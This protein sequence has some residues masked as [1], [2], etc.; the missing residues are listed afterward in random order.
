M[1]NLTREELEAI[2]LIK[3]ERAIWTDMQVQLTDKVYFN[4]QN[5]IK[6]AKK[7][8]FGVF[9]DQ[10]D[11]VTK[12]KK[13]WLPLSRD[14]IETTVKNI[15]IDSK[16][17]SVRAKKPDSYYTAALVRYLL[18]AYLD[19]IN[20]GQLLNRVIRKCSTEGVAVLKK[21]NNGKNLTVSLVENLNFLTD[22]TCNYLKES[23]GN[24][25]NHWLTNY[26]LSTYAWDNLD[27]VVGTTSVERIQNYPVPSQIPY[28][29]ITERWGI[30]PK[31]LLTQNPADKT[32]Y[33]EGVIIVSNI[34]TNP[35]VH[36]IAENKTGKRPY[37]EFRTKMYDGRWLGIGVAEDLFDLQA[38]INEIFNIRL[39]TARIKQL[40]LFEI[41]KG[42]GITP[43]K[44]AQLYAGGGIL[45]SQ[46]GRDI[47]ELQTTDTKV[48]SYKDEDQAY[49]WSQRLTGAWEIGR[50][51]QLPATMP[52]TTAMLQQ[53]GM[54]TGFSLQQEELG[55]CISQFIEDLILPDMLNNLTDKDIVRITGDPKELKALDDTYVNNLVNDE[56]VNY[57]GRNGYYPT[58]M[59]IES[60]KQKLMTELAKQG[61]DRFLNIKKSIFKPNDIVDSVD[62]FVTGEGFD[63]MVM[64]RQLNDL[65]VNYSRI[66]GVNIDQDKIVAELLDLMGL[67][68]ERFIRNQPVQPVPMN[69][70]LAPQ[71][72]PQQPVMQVQG[73]NEQVA[74]ATTMERGMM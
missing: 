43:Q 69:P 25:E 35:I 33:T 16:D 71:Q 73:G 41:R 31:N 32:K 22:P 6:K 12:K 28:S 49:L 39:N 47:K 72:A 61:K 3:S 62:I 51:E 68:S 14:M 52:A 10:Y 74:N 13:I 65:L 2:N 59:E 38:Y 36:L 37:Q 44:L 23:A 70:S 11:P 58:E 66:A 20:F 56:I 42:S 45:V 7:N 8:Y 24:H 30:I 17:I 63:K 54:N 18:A 26:E 29:K 34:D 4:C 67:G 55:F 27:K 57:Y 19:K 9:D 53:Q 40:G 46:L 21:F 5:I 48:S 1:P 50:G 15:D 64:A 60:E